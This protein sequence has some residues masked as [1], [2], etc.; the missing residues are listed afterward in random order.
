MNIDDRRKRDLEL[1]H[2]NKEKY[3]RARRD[4]YFRKTLD[5]RTERQRQKEEKVR[6]QELAQAAKL[7]AAPRPRSETQEFVQKVKERPCVDCGN[8]FPA[9]VMEF[10]HRI[11]E[12]KSFNLSRARDYSFAQVV[13]EIAKCD[14]VCANCHRV[15]T[16]RQRNGLPATLPEPEYFI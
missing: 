5:T 6:A 12:E 14:L 15:R 4:A 8:R 3:N 1:W 11:A 7:R 2:K 10:D 16:W 13:E 9:P